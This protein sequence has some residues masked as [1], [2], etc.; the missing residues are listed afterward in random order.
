VILAHGRG[1]E[2]ALDFHSPP[3]MYSIGLDLINQFVRWIVDI[4]AAP[5]T[6]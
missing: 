6:G 4:C 1:F 3:I 5:L 2:K